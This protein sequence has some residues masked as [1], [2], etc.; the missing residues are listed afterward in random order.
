MNL[1]L[2]QSGNLQSMNHKPPIQLG[3]ILDL[4][5]NNLFPKVQ[6]VKSEWMILKKTPTQ[7]QTCQLMVCSCTRMCPLTPV[8]I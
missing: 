7:P 3:K 6:M 5:F 1:N 2:P 8:F 4:A